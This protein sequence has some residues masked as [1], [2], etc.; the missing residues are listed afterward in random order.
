MGLEKET[1]NLDS[2]I[3]LFRDLGKQHLIG[4]GPA[5]QNEYIKNAS[6]ESILKEGEHSN[7]YGQR[8]IQEL[9]KKY[10]NNPNGLKKHAE[11]FRQSMM[12]VA[13]QDAA[14]G[15]EANGFFNNPSSFT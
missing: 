6:W 9:R 10:K 7:G 14:T 3:A 12:Y 8:Y 13:M 11:L 4:K 5:R 1:T 2:R 15:I